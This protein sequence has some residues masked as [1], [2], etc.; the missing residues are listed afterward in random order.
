LFSYFRLFR[1]LFFSSST[2]IEDA[3]V[4]T[5][6]G[7]IMKRSL[8]IWIAILIA[9]GVVKSG[10]KYGLETSAKVNRPL[11]QHNHKAP[12]Q[13]FTRLP[14]RFETNAGQSD[15]RVKFLARGPGYSLFLT[16]QEAIIRLRREHAV[17][18]LQMRWLESNPAP[19]M[20]GQSKQPGLTNYFA[21]TDAS[22]WRQGI[23]SYGQV[24]YEKVW[25][26]IDLIFYGNQQQLEYDFRLAPGANPARIRMA[27]DGADSV[28]VDPDGSLVLEV[29]GGEVRWLK[30]VA[31]QEVAGHR[32]DIACRYRVTRLGRENRVEFAL[33]A[34][35]RRLPLVID[36]ALVY[37]TFLG[38]FLEDYAY[39]VA[40]DEAGNTYVAGS[41][42]S[43]DFL[44]VNPLQPSRASQPQ[45]DAFVLKIAPNGGNLVYATY[46][47]GTGTDI[48][49]SIAVD[50]AGNVY[51]TGETA[52]TDFPKAAAGAQQQ[53]S[54]Y[55]DAFL[56]K[57]NPSGS[58]LVYSTLLGG[59]YF[60]R[61]LSVAIDANGSAYIAGQTDSPNFPL[62]GSTRAAD[63]TNLFKTTDAAAN[64]NASA[65]GLP[66]STVHEIAFSPNNSSE[67]FAATALGLFK[68]A[69]SGA[70]WAAVG[71]LPSISG[72]PVTVSA[73]VFDSQNPSVIYLG[74]SAG[75]YKSFNSG[76]SFQLRSIGLSN[77]NIAGLVI[78]PAQPA[79][80]YAATP[81]GVFKTTDG[82]ETWLA[83][84]SGL[85]NL[86]INNI[87]ISSSD[88]STLYVGTARGVFKTINGGTS[89]T[90][91]SNGLGPAASLPAVTG[92]AIDPASPLTLYAAVNTTGTILFKTIDGGANWRASDTGLTAMVGGMQ[93]RPVPVALAIH[94]ATPAT[95]YAATPL[96]VFKTTDGGGAW[97]SM[98]SGLTNLNITALAIDPTAANTVYAG[99]F[100]C[101]DAFVT[102][103]NANGSTILYSLVFGG[104][105]CDIARGIAVDASGAAWVTGDTMSADF[106]SIIPLQ[107][108]ISGAS[109]A[110][111][112][113]VNP[114]GAALSFST[115]LGGSGTEAGNGITLDAAGNVIIVGETSSS[116]FPAANGYKTS[117]G[118]GTDGFIAKYKADGSAVEFAS[119]FGGNSSDQIFAVAV[120]KGGDIWVTGS[121]QSSDFPQ[122]RPLPNTSSQSLSAF[123]SRFSAVGK[124]LIFSSRFGGGFSDVGRAVAVG[125]GNNVYLAGI[126]NSFSFPL[127]NPVPASN[128]TPNGFA[129][130]LGPVADLA[131]TIAGA[132]APVLAGER[133]TY[134]VNVANH[135]DL[136]LTGVKLTDQLPSGATLV[137]ATATQGTCNIASE[138][139]CDLGNLAEASTAVL[140]IVVSA[141]SS[142]TISNTV[143]VSAAE[144]EPDTEN[145]TS[146][147]SVEIATADIALVVT[148][149][150]LQIAPG[151]RLTWL[152]TVR[153][154]SGRRIP[155]IRISN[156]LPAETTFVSCVA[157]Q[158]G[159]CGGGGN[160]RSAT[161]ESLDANASATVLMTAM[162]NGNVAPGGSITNVARLEPTLY[163]PNPNNN[164][165]RALT[166]VVPPLPGE[167]T[168]GLI[169]FSSATAGYFGINLIRPDGGG[170][171]LFS[172]GQSPTWSPDGTRLLVN[173]GRPAY[174]I[175]ADG[176]GLRQLTVAGDE[177]GT[178]WS[179]DGTRIA[180]YR[181]SDGV[182]I[183]NADG[184]GERNILRQFTN[185]IGVTLKWS[186]DGA[187]LLIAED[188]L[189][190]LYV[191]NIDGSGVTR[192]TTASSSTPHDQP[193]WS[194]DGAKIVFVNRRDNPNGELYLINADGSGLTRLTNNNESE[195]YPAWSPDGKKIAYGSGG[196][197]VMINADATSPVRFTGGVNIGL[198]WQRAPANQP[199]MLAISGRL[200]GSSFDSFASTMVELT[201]TRNIK[202]T[203]STD[204]FYSFGLLPAG[205]TYTVRPSSTFFR[206][207]PQSRTFTNLTADQVNTDFTSS[208]ISTVVRGRVTDFSGAP[209]AGVSVTAG[210]GSGRAETD[211]N[212]NYVI[213]GLSGSSFTITPG[214][215][216]SSA[217]FEPAFVVLPPSDGDR[218]ANFKGTREPFTLSGRVT[219]G[220]GAAVADVSITLNGGGHSASTITNSQGLYSFPGLPSGHVYT[221]GAAKSGIVMAPATRRVVLRSN[222]DVRFFAGVSQL[223]GVSAPAYDPHGVTV[224]GVVALFG[225]GLATMTRAATGTSLPLTL[226]G[227]SVHLTNRN[228][229]NR[230][231]GLFFVSPQQINAA[232]P[233]IEFTLDDA[234]LYA[235]ETL[236]EVRRG[237]QVLAA[238]SVEIERVAPGIFT[239]DSSG[240]GLAA[241]VA[242]RVRSDNSQVF[243]P[244]FRF[245]PQT[246]QFV[247]VP[248]DI[249]SSAEQVFLVLFATGVRYRIDAAGVRVKIASEDA[250]VSFAGPAPGL[251]GVD[252]V[253]ALIP[254]S[255]IG[256]GEVEV[257]LIADG[258]ESNRTKIHIR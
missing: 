51:V 131:V 230:Q 71:T 130:K 52:S 109:D 256:R 27:F 135:G 121:S 117:S 62:I 129:M 248:I 35:D 162:V 123:V 184:S 141:P 236:I 211:A 199:R 55:T 119:Y 234:S 25:K 20:T 126:A 161:I 183:I 148:P 110:F 240:S 226:E 172:T 125:A 194:P 252:Q 203:A 204:G 178:T 163:D 116:N 151:G 23:E 171:F 251:V 224:A 142:P 247:A 97:N 238:G 15:P 54:G 26:D 59:S 235:G 31:Y 63:F 159:S 212:G 95:I 140:T 96:G 218:F 45:L 40:A 80:L 112:A 70:Q 86:T 6:R 145:N 239:A 57:L 100:T 9:L 19:R 215:S 118:G 134:T 42:N 34:Y 124:Q 53:P 102:K 143:R 237:T 155:S 213:T 115:F 242:L 7:K 13:A 41:T 56:I 254:K 133:L 33:E 217:T 111:V 69:D 196:D 39:S 114:A 250:M 173:I 21:G 144:T 137:S 120:D 223:T 146:T 94:P 164:E 105:D 85:N 92:L 78:N 197:I 181:F 228:F 43:P 108:G 47:G 14:L 3:I 88:R 206:F 233:A 229:A 154:L 83:H 255:L 245:D 89:W 149:S 132:P 170:R 258:R 182:F 200:R 58:Q 138:I 82:G 99:S 222:L 11:T 187:K 246:R 160:D 107:A 168:N 60:D 188:Q 214:S 122:V 101:T 191:F 90:I 75:V 175:N 48:A 12:G 106:P 64:W 186:P 49:Y 158:G 1:H 10:V 195:R 22:R 176:T 257:I 16:P 207:N 198:D 243:E 174:I 127:I 65:N 44:T 79:T 87:V 73:I 67:V 50:A 208:R 113:M 98:S 32:L 219:D 72:T 179:P 77:R 169:A 8:S 253:N 244:L 193:D 202:V 66:N 185:R 209:M 249:S 17:S 76:Q 177:D 210:S 152:L 241:A 4:F 221:V 30:P 225:Q 232:L 231:C 190:G 2:W 157:P 24:K 5:N 104:S 84:N 165:D 81:A 46:L 18:Q 189:D 180:F 128:G 103:V 91:A 28:R 139:I 61:A 156:T 153:N 147:V 205:G 37:S 216:Q 167:T 192:L 227:V 29:G 220:G 36:P 166:M 93:T 150:H 74:T 201:G 136:P 38:G 68:S